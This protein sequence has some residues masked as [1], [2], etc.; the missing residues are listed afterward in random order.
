[1]KSKLL[2]V[3]GDRHAAKHKAVSDTKANGEAVQTVRMLH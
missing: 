1:M 2:A 3:R